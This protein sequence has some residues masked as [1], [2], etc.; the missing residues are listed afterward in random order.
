MT[1][2]Q[3]EMNLQEPESKAQPVPP[4]VHT[5]DVKQDRIDL[6]NVGSEHAFPDTNPDKRG[7]LRSIYFKASSWKRRFA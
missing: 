3:K 1:A 2:S 5:G 6:V 4:E 7:R